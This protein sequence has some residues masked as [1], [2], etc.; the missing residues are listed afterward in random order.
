MAPRVPNPDGLV[1]RRGQPLYLIPD[2]D[3]NGEEI[4]RIFTDDDE[5]DAWI[6]RQGVDFR[7]S[8]GIWAGLDWD[9]MTEALDRIRHERRPTAPID[10]L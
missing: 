9:E 10:E 6:A 4:E 7:S 1:H 8:R 5:L 2:V 3:E